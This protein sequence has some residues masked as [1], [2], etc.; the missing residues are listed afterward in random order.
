Q[1]PIVR[2]IGLP[3]GRLRL[4]QIT[5]R[6]QQPAMGDQGAIESV[7]PLE[8]YLSAIDDLAHPG[9]NRQIVTLG[10]DIEREPHRSH[11]VCRR[12]EAI[13]EPERGSLALLRQ[14]GCCFRTPTL[15]RAMR[16]A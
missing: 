12:V 10:R 5:V 6:S 13:L 2:V 7:G 14:A 9:E 3:L 8:A 4:V 11:D 1:T 16:G 15:E